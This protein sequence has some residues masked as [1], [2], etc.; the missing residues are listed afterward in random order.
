MKRR[1]VTEC[2]RL[3]GRERKKEKRV[4]RRE[5]E[6]WS[7]RWAERGGGL[8]TERGSV[9]AVC[10]SSQK[11]A[12]IVLLLPPVHLSPTA[13]FPSLVPLCV[14]VRVEYMTPISFGCVFCLLCFCLLFKARQGACKWGKG[15]GKRWGGRAFWK[16]DVC[17]AF[18][19]EQQ[20]ICLARYLRCCGG[21]NLVET[22][23]QV[24]T[25][26]ATKPTLLQARTETMPLLRLVPH[27][28]QLLAA[29]NL[30]LI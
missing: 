7:I 11:S 16:D 6:R 17:C 26:P 4:R 12:T 24:L 30:C 14:R 10:T 29:I 22:G 1:L 9:S 5:K 27:S 15:C 8:G 2:L 21:P 19:L 18:N 23:L 13:P 3:K 20:D 28:P 25:W